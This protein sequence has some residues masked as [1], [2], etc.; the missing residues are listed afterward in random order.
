M[1]AST[2]GLVATNGV[3][4]GTTVPNAALH[5]Y[6]TGGVSLATTGTVNYTNT[7]ILG[8]GY[9]GGNAGTRD[10]FRIISQAVNRDNGAGPTFYDYGVQADL[11]FVRKTNGSYSY[12][13]N[14]ITYTEAVRIHG[15]SGFMGIGT[16]LPATPLHV[17]SPSTGHPSII[18]INTTISSFGTSANGGRLEW[19]GTFTGNGGA[20]FQAAIQGIDD[21]L[22]DSGYGGLAFITVN[23]T[24][25]R[26][27]MRISSVG[28]VGI[29]TN[30]PISMLDVRGT[31]GNAAYWSTPVLNVYGGTGSDA[32]NIVNFQCQ[33]SQYGRNILYM[34][35]RYELAND[36]WNFATPR[37][38][39]VFQ[40]QSALNSAATQ[41]F[42]I[43]N[44]AGQLGILSNGGSNTPITVWMDNGNV[45]IGT[46]NSNFQL[47][48]YKDSPG[49]LFTSSS[50]L[51]NSW[52]LFV[53]TS[54]GAMYLAPNVNSATPGCNVAIGASAW[55]ATSD[56]RLKKSITPLP[57]ALDNILQLNPILFQYK[58]DS[59]SETLRE[60]FIAQEVRS[61][62][63]SKWVVSET[64]M[65]EKQVDDNGDLYDALSVSSTQL[66]P[67]LVK[68][69]QELSQ[70]VTSSVSQIQEL[71]S[72]ATSSASLVQEL[73][74]QTAQL[75][76]ENTQL[77][78][79]MALLEARLAALESK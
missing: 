30:A 31:I 32:S 23:N 74:S 57:S 38:A 54:N 6:G 14:D 17:F 10:S 72:Q 16:Y 77:K 29:G 56:A 22:G 67:H 75:A 42:S 44:F 62:F 25:Q 26:E 70:T 79:A 5:V 8:F 1:Y 48:L 4:I 78:S 49:I 63:P 64:G 24:T 9:G 43:Q 34:T 18:R 33:A 59:D 3:G 61:I 55:A 40:T 46:T 21:V 66:I 2:I 28:N 45:G 39:I 71:A 7:S 15:A 19:Y 27:S 51:S 37:N 36:G 68:S 58:T 12:G 73:A 11:V 47:H 35:G 69:I 13:A 60:G 65:P 41:R 20:Y 76:I 50:F 53:G 52:Y